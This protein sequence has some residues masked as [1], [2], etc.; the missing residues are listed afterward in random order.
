MYVES[1]PNRNSPPATLL[2]ESFRDGGQVRKRTLANISDWPPAQ[3]ES[4]ADSPAVHDIRS[5]GTQGNNH[6]N[7][8]LTTGK[9]LERIGAAPISPYSTAS[10]I[11]TETLDRI[12]ALYGIEREILEQ[13][14]ETTHSCQACYRL[15]RSSISMCLP[16]GS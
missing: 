9:V 6:R 10:P 7:G 1:V 2:R 16:A 11:T 12:G 8:Q 4:R 15:S 3:V 14:V 13:R 5:Y